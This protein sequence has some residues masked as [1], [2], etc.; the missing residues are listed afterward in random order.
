MTAVPS[1]ATNLQGVSSAFLRNLLL[2][3]SPVQLSVTAMS[4]LN[5]YFRS[6]RRDLTTACA[7]HA[8]EVWLQ[9]H[10]MIINKSPGEREGHTPTPLGGQAGHFRVRTSAYPSQ[11]VEI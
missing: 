9:A 10:C 7:C 2:K 1:D 5:F 8:G 6:S 4:S 3:V 11:S